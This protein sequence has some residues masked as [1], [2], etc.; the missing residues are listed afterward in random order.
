LKASFLTR[1]TTQ[2][3][4][5]AREGKPRA[6]TVLNTQTNRTSGHKGGKPVELVKVY[7]LRI[8]TRPNGTYFKPNYRRWALLII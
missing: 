6:K 1:E 7:D 4:R 8:L 3:T 2:V 5:E